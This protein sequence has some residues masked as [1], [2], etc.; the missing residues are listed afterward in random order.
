MLKI[1]RK[2]SVTISIAL[3][4]LMFLGTV[5]LAFFLPSFLEYLLGLP[6]RNGELLALTSTQRTVVYAAAYTELFLMASGLGML[7][8]LLI[9]VKRGSVFTKAAVELIRYISWCL[10]FMGF[11]MMSMAFLTLLAVAAGAAILFV[12]LTIRVT[13]NVIEEAVYIK[14]ENDLTV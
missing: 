7:F 14:E 13:K 10:I 8:A 11:I 3:T 4:A 6:D 12:G 1:N 5:V 9:L 2:L